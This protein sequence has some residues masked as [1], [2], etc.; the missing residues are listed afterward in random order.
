MTSR[1]GSLLLFFVLGFIAGCGEKS[2]SGPEKFDVVPA[3]GV[4]TYKGKSVP[5]ASVSFQSLDGKVVSSGSTDGVGSFVLSTYGQQ[6]G[7]PP[8]KYR[9]VVSAVNIREIEP[10]VLEPE[11]PGGFKSSI[12]TKYGNPQTTDILVEVTQGG[13]NDF[14]IELK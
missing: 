4:V 8:G 7:I 14:S 10:G 13:K 11:P 6:D 1:V 5:N 3:R 12:P 9:V 2:S